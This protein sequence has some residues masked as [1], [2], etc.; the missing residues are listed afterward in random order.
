[1]TDYVG[2]YNPSNPLNLRVAPISS[3]DQLNTLSANDWL[4]PVQSTTPS[5]ANGT[6]G[7][8]NTFG[9]P[10]APTGFLAGLKG[11]GSWIGENGQAIGGIANLIGQGFQAYTGLKALSLAKNQLQ[12][13]KKSF[14][15]NLA[16]AVD[17]YN[18]QTRDRLTGRW[19]ATEEERQAALKE[20]ELPQGMRG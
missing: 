19:Y 8:P 17:S 2:G 5:L 20:A 16:N 14:K 11:L 1:M 10:A 18:T 13:E 9:T 4:G 6:Y 7:M 12:F 15:T 3:F